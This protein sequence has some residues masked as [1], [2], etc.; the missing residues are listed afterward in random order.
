[1]RPSASAKIARSPSPSNATPIRHRCSRTARASRSGCVEPQ[2]RLMLRPSGDAPISST[3]KPSSANS[4]GATVVVAPLAASIA[5]VA[6]AQTAPGPAEAGACARCTRRRRSCC[7]SAPRRTP[8]T[9]QSVA[10]DDRLDLALERFGE[11]LALAREDLDAVVLERIVR[12]RDHDAGVERH[13]RRDVRDRRRR[14]HA[15]ARHRRAL[16]SRAARQL[17]ARSTRRTRA[18]RGR[19]RTG[20]DA[21][22]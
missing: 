10:R 1:M 5:S 19:R 17:L 11:L 8:G 6:A 22:A 18:Y 21:P 12:R 16:R 9:A 14:D 13:R 2:S 20:A 4:R 7:R 15:G 3:S